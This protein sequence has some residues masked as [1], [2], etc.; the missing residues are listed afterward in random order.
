MPT[1]HI[2]Y[3]KG[4]RVFPEHC[5]NIEFVSTDNITNKSKLICKCGSVFQNMESSKY[6]HKLS[7]KHIRYFKNNLCLN[8]E[9]MYTLYRI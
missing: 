4:E 5:S 7:A 9:E 1:T 6:S 3:Y 2:V 8:N